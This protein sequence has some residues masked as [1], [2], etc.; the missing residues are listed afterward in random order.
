MANL[1]S[2]QKP[3]RVLSG[4][5]WGDGLNGPA[6]LSSTPNT[7]ATILATAGQ[8]SATCGAST[9]ANGDLVVLMQMYGTGNG[10]FEFNMIS[11]GGGTTSLVMAVPHQFSYIAGAQI[12]KV[13]RN[14]TVTSNAHSV[15]SWD[16]SKQGVEIIVA[17]TSVTSGGAINAAGNNGVNSATFAAGAVGVGF[18]GGNMS[19]SAQNQAG[20]TGGAPTTSYVNNGN[21]GGSGQ[22]QD[23]DGGGGGNA[24]AGGNAPFQN[25]YNGGVGG[26]AAGTADLTNIVMG[27][28]GGGGNSNNGWGSASNER[29]SGGAGGGIVII[30]SKS[31]TL[32]H[33]INLNGGGA[34]SAYH[35]GG[36]GAGGSCLLVCETASIGSNNITA[37]G[38]AVTRSP[39][40]SQAGDGSVGRVAVHHSGS[41]SGTSNPTFTDVSDTSLIETGGSGLLTMFVG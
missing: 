39:L 21:G 32:T 28:G 29:A 14:T 20:G 11:S 23:G 35:G 5:P 27:G 30:F 1:A 41:I 38:G 31:I 12:I 15:S 4:K 9:F 2:Y 36:A 33:G 19:N 16:G 10:Q 6:T 40:N 18:Q 3:S 37:I 22:G 8:T 7:H 25:G 13:P 26:S 17:N 24:A 34:P